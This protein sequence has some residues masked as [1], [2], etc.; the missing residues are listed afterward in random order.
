MDPHLLF[1]LFKNI[2]CGVADRKAAQMRQLIL[3]AV[4]SAQIAKKKKERSRCPDSEKIC[5]VVVRQ[6]GRGLQEK[7]LVVRPLSAVSHLLA[8]R[9]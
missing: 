1:C 4:I 3:I 6:L 7:R 2:F 9:R 5:T 8:E